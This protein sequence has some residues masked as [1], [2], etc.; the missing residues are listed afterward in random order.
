M[1][2]RRIEIRNAR[3]S[4]SGNY[5]CIVENEAGQARKKFD[6]AVLGSFNVQFQII[7]FTYSIASSMS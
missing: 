2:D 4:D 6:L 5:V 3:L 1:N 7:R